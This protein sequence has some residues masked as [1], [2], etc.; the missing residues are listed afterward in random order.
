MF[1]IG[2]GEFMLLAVVLIIAVGPKAMPTFMKTVGKG[3]RQFRQ[4][5]QELRDQMGI[6]ELM[7]EDLSLKPPQ[8]RRSGRR[9]AGAR[10]QSPRGGPLELTAA[11]REREFPPEGVD[12]RVA[13]EQAEAAAAEPRSDS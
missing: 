11:D 4:A 13:N 5:Q 8:S 6:D 12:L 2:L 1:G 3:M 7:R 9:G 10:S